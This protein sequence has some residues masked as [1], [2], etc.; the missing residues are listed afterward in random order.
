VQT[1]RHAPKKIFSFLGAQ[2]LDEG[3]NVLRYLA[4]GNYVGKHE[5]RYMQSIGDVARM[6]LYVHHDF[7]NGRLSEHDFRQFLR[8]FEEHKKSGVKKLKT[9]KPTPSA[10]AIDFYK[11]AML[12]CGAIMGI[13]ARDFDRQSDPRP[14]PPAKKVSVRQEFDRTPV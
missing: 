11:G 5:L 10:E 7:S 8:E 4:E 1:S 2:N 6:G 13:I 9:T 14:A 12:V 3:L